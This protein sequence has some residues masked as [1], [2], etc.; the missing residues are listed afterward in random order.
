MRRMPIS[1]L[2]SLLVSTVCL[3][4]VTEPIPLAPSTT[5]VGPGFPPPAPPA[6]P[7]QPVPVAPP[8]PTTQKVETPVEIIKEEPP[9]DTTPKPGRVPEFLGDQTPISSMLILPH[10]TIEGSG[11]LFAPSARYFKISD[12]DSPRPQ[13]REYFSFNY[14]YGLDNSLNQAAGA[15]IQHTRIHRE[16]FGLEWAAPDG[17]LSFGLRLPI[18]TYNAAHTM[19]GLDGTSTD[20][21]DLG[22]IFKYA[23]WEDA[24]KGSLVS[25]G[26]AV[27]PTTGPGS[28]GGSEHLKVFHNTGLQPFVGWILPLDRFYLQGFTA[29]DAVTDLNDVILLSNDIAAGYF[30]YHNYKGH[31]ITAVV[32]V[33]ELHVSTP[34]NHRGV[35]SMTDPAGAPDQVNLTVGVNFEYLDKSS[36]GLAF[37]VPLAGPRTFDFEILAQWR[38]RF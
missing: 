3:A 29:V 22:L 4:Q 6:L 12:N 1:C 35:L 20:L 9:R 2:V 34:L 33:A 13:S 15:G 19:D 36:A 37:A 14:F 25:A 17:S 28:F 23:L 27:V 5:F 10:G 11:V 24:A 21:G 30:L 16:I 8:T 26:L 18:D 31:S 7:P 32:P 38:V